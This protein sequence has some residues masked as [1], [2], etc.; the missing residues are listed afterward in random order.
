MRHNVRVRRSAPL[1]GVAA[2]AM[3]LLGATTPAA[4]QPGG[5]QPAE[6]SDETGTPAG[7]AQ[8]DAPVPEVDWAACG[9]G[10]EQFDCTSVEVPSDDRKSVGQGKWREQA[11]S[12]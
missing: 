8:V 11:W 2:A 3:L 4:A 10:L 1:A 12:R 5:A 9:E 7:T 6:R